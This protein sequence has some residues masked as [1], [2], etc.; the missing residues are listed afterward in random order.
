MDPWET[1]EVKL[2]F[3]KVDRRAEPISGRELGEVWECCRLLVSDTGVWYIV[4]V[5]FSCGCVMSVSMGGGRCDRWVLA[6]AVDNPLSICWGAAWSSVSTPASSE[7]CVP[8][9][10]SCFDF[11]PSS[12]AD[13]PRPTTPLMP[14][15][16]NAV[17]PLE[18]TQG[19]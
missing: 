8:E 4:G 19:A 17:K 15:R 9:A 12:P 16:M 7:V 10:A 14:C 2:E 11:R 18:V 3:D 13:R 6:I 5:S 1:I